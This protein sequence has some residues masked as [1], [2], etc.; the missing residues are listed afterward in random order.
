MCDKSK[1]NLMMELDAEEVYQRRKRRWLTYGRALLTIGVLGLITVALYSMTQV[2]GSESALDDSGSSISRNDIAINN[3]L[4]NND[5][6]QRIVKRDLSGAG[7]HDDYGDVKSASGSDENSANEIPDAATNLDSQHRK[8]Q[9][10][11]QQSN[12]DVLHRHTSDGGVYIFKGYK[13]IP[14]SKPSKQLE[15]LRA[16]H[17]VGMLCFVCCLLYFPPARAY[18][19]R[20]LLGRFSI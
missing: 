13:C 4:V 3:E 14:I 8:L 9:Q 16:R 18:S 6:D 12:N 10:R 5:D 2:R 7:E 20:C 15:N 17:R 1:R 11:R 19:L